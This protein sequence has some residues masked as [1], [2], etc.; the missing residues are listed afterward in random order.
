TPSRRSIRLPAAPGA[1]RAGSAT[2]GDRPRA[3]AVSRAA[4][5][6]RHAD[7]GPTAEQVAAG[8]AVYTKR[9]LAVYDVA[10]LRILC[11]VVWRCPSRRIVE[12][13]A[14]HVPANPLDIGV[15]PGYF[16]DRCRSPSGEGRLALLDLNPNCLERSAR[17]VA[18]YRPEVHRANVLEPIRLRMP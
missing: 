9:L 6:R 4:T 16:L 14:A 15:G 3:A 11:R 18:R 10:V 5:R 1:T 7:M 13:Y 2:V 12:L 8:Q 17:R